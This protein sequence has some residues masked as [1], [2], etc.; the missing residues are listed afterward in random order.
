[1]RSLLSE[2]FGKGTLSMFIDLHA[3][4]NKKGAFV[5]G[6]SF[7]DVQKQAE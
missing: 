6:E 2:E 3:H 7:G 4:T 5:F 1:M